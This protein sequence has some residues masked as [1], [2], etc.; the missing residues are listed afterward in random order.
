MGTDGVRRL[1]TAIA[2]TDSSAFS[3]TWYAATTWYDGDATGGTHETTPSPRAAFTFKKR[4]RYTITSGDIP[5][6]GGTDDPD[7]IRVYLADGLATTLYR[8]ATT[9]GRREFRGAHHGHV[10]RHRRAG[11]KRLSRGRSPR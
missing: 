6:L 2:W 11:L 4:S 7:R 8:Q 10:L 3:K 5:D 1:H 9:A